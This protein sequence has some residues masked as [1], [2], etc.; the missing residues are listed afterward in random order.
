MAHSDARILSAPHRIHFAGWH[1]T[2]LD[3][4]Q[5]G[6]SLSAEQD[7]QRMGIRIAMTHRD[8]KMRGITESVDDYHFFGDPLQFGRPLDFHV[9]YMANDLV[10]QM[11][12]NLSMFRPIDAMPQFITTE[13]KSIDDFGIFAT[14]LVRTQELIVEPETVMELLEKIKAMQSPE[15]FE[16]RKRMQARKRDSGEP[17]QR[18]QFHAQILSLVA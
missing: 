10:V 18:Q 1:T 7:M 9:R 16:I 17:I 13:R 5:H 2:L 8:L 11:M 12:D 15:Q 3:L 4:Q 6:G 14:P